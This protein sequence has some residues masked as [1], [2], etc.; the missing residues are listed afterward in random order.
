[1]ARSSTYQ[2][3]SWLVHAYTAL[4]GVLGFLALLAAGVGE[5]RLAFL[6]LMAALFVDVTD[7][8][9]ARRIGVQHHLPRFSGARVDDAIDVLT[10]IYV[11]LFIVVQESLLPHP[12]WIIPAILAG[13][14]AYGQTDMKTDDGFFLGFPS[15]WNVVA[16]YLFWLR[17]P[18]VVAIAAILIPAV[19][20]VIPTR[21]LYPSKNGFFWKSNFILCGLWLVLVIVL[22]L[23]PV[24]SRTAISI[25]LVYPALYMLMSFY[26]E[27]R[28]RHNR[29]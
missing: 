2:A 27:W 16:L 18:P 11:P 12:A 17:P 5:S 6:W 19:L 29:I 28:L 22:L 26:A 10:Y 21:Y 24:P 3:L 20:T 14:Y 8:L 1:M 4:G 25:S 13:L 9:L 7:G 15:Y 23:Q